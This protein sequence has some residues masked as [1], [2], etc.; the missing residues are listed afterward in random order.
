[1]S[2]AGGSQVLTVTTTVA[3]AEAARELA[4][5]I[6]DQHLAA[7]VQVDTAITSFY[8]WKGQACEDAEVRLV[9]KTLPGC[10]AALRQLFAERHPYELPQFVAVTGTASPEYA[11]WVAAE[12]R[13]PGS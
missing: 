6:L 11:A 8:R 4:R 1:M 7:C 5:L 3:T 9:I 13:I 2:Q 12:V 10:E